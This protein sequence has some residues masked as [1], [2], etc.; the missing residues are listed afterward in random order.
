MIDES[1]E[2]IQTEKN[3][4]EL[5][6]KMMQEDYGYKIEWTSEDD[7]RLKDLVVR[8]GVFQWEELAGK[9]STD[10]EDAKNRWIKAVFPRIRNTHKIGG[11]VKWSASED[12]ILYGA[13]KHKVSYLDLMFFLPGRTVYSIEARWRRIAKNPEFIGH[14]ALINNREAERQNALATIARKRH[15]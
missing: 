7:V 1:E 12:S 3:N 10:E 11:A 13:D 6:K 4:H 14:M 15:E 5:I 8:H 2:D 9:F